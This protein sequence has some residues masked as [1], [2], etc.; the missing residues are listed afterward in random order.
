MNVKLPFGADALLTQEGSNEVIGVVKKGDNFA[1]RMKQALEAHFD[2]DVN[3][4]ST[5][6]YDYMFDYVGRY[7]ITFDDGSDDIINDCILITPV[8]YY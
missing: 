6:D 3:I 1:E 2:A 7:H 8:H 4:T 5:H